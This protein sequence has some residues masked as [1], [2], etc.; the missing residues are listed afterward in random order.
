MEL[1][2]LLIPAGRPVFRATVVASLRVLG[3]PF[4]YCTTADALA[5]HRLHLL[6][7]LSNSAVHEIGSPQDLPLRINLGHS[8]YSHQCQEKERQTW[9]VFAIHCW[10]WS[11]E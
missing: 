6:S 4:D 10:P 11:S 3:T 7:S 9:E 5:S 1:S 2:V 8:K